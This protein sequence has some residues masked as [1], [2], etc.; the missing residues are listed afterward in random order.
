MKEEK[1]QKKDGSEGVKY[2]LEAGDKVVSRFDKPR[3]NTQGNY[4][5]YSLGITHP[6]KGDIY[7][8]LTPAQFEKLDKIG[9]L[10]GKTIEAYEYENEY[11]KQKNTKYVGVKIAEQ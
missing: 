6:E 3:S 10:T 2:T 4:P 1:F 5:N 8:Q 11:S 7:V 9:N